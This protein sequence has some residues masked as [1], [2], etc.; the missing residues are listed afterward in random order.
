MTRGGVVVTVGPDAGVVERQLRSGALRCPGCRGVLRAWG[1]ARPRWLRSDP[2]SLRPVQRLAPRRAMC[3]SCGRTHVLSP[4]T[5]LSRRA[6]GV[7]VIG[8]A[9]L[10]RARGW[11]YR[12]VAARVGRP[13]S[14]VRG[15]LGRVTAN[16][17]RIFAA[18]VGL[19]HELEV[20]PA[21]VAPAG[22]PFADAVA[23][24][25]AGVAAVRRRFG[26]AVVVVSAW[27][28]A[29]GLTHGRLLAPVPPS[30]LIN[31]S[32]HLAGFS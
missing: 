13:I 15:W 21:P 1:W 12:R 29:A 8:A 24:V 18:F 27:R 30:R 4:V 3:G 14:T 6:D 26:V 31:T 22:S 11:G 20:D 17:E 25:G 9:L 5:A 28:V 32:W 19:A 2:G 16:A 23:A 10:A 7:E